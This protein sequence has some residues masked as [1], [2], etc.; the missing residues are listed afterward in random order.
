MNRPLLSICIPTYRK[1]HALYEM[2]S[3]FLKTDNQEFEIVVSD[4]H[5]PDDS[6][7]TLKQIRD[8]RFKLIEN[9]QNNGSY[10][11]G[12]VAFE[13]AQGKYILLL[14][15]KDF[16]SSKN[17]EEAMVLIRKE[18]FYIGYFDLNYDKEDGYAERF[19]TK[20]DCLLNFAYG[21]RHPSGYIFNNDIFKQKNL[22][23][24]FKNVDESVMAFFVDFLAAEYTEYQKG[25]VF[26]LDM[27]KMSHPPYNGLK[28]SFT[29]S[30]AKHNLFYTPENRFKA[31]NAFMNNLNSLDLTPNE[32]INVTVELL[33]QL[34][35]QSTSGYIATLNNQATSDWYNVTNSFKNREL[36]RDLEKDFAEKLSNYD[37]FKNSDEKNQILSK[38]NKYLA[39]NRIKSFKKNVLKPLLSL[40]FKEIH[41]LIKQYFHRQ[42]V[43]K[44]YKKGNINLLWREINPHNETTVSKHVNTDKVSVENY[45]YGN[46]SMY[47]SGNGDEKLTIGNYCSIAPEVTF[48]LSSEHGYKNISTYPFKVKFLGE[49]NE[50][51]SKGS[52]TVGDDVWI[53]YGAII[54]SG[55]SLGQGAIIGAGSLVTKDVPPYAI[56]AGNPAKILKYRFEPA[57]IE[58]LMTID[59]SELSKE[60]IK[61]LSEYIYTELT[62]ENIDEIIKFFG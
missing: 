3:G 56:V 21:S 20:Q 39:K 50:A 25:V 54:M 30:P 22:L 48:L 29:Y 47:H 11:N 8:N 18:E 12:L 51:G 13:H 41:K 43:L 62:S 2:I 36:F 40:K 46:I 9:E 16:I 42:R 55:V 52:I 4:N 53:G 23:E 35:H 58:K 45:T 26:H 5:S 28:H 49:E 14:M 19:Y 27:V 33:K 37:N 24:R 1:G 6:V 38:F 31:F 34:H 17:L 10:L 7:E 61:K 60:K 59:F 15:D 57:V 32:R 44:Q